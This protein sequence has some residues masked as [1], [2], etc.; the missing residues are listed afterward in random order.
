VVIKIKNRKQKELEYED[1]YSHIPIDFKERL[2][3]MIDKYKI[4][5]AK[6]DEIISV[7]NNMMMNLFFTELNIVLYEEPE[8]TPRSR[9]RLINRQNLINEALTNS[10]FV[11]VYS[12]NAKE[13][14]LYMRRLIDNELISIQELLCTPC[15]VEYNTY[16]RTP[17]SYNSVKV[18]LAE[19][20]LDR[21]I[22]KPDWDN[23]GK[24]YSD[25]S[26]HNIWIDDILTISGSV[27]KLYSIL[28]RIEIKLRYLNSVY[29]KYQYDAITK[30][31]DF[32]EG[33]SLNYI[34]NRGEL[35]CQ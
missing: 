28:P 4:S 13:D 18:F 24:K 1:K 20:G 12:I 31:K 14:S 30:R 26:N 22:K 10:N 17:S 23:I 16:H 33:M 15:I 34:N 6:M 3:W 8:G 5:P 25:M 21:P 11:H 7:R 27:H 29:N 2:D 32:P 9:F 35:I 19:I